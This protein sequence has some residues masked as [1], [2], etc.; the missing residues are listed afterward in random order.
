MSSLVF[1][2]LSGVSQT[3]VGRAQM[4]HIATLSPTNPISGHVTGLKQEFSSVQC[5][6]MFDYSVL[7]S[8]FLVCNVGDKH[9]EM[10]YLDLYAFVVT[11]FVRKHLSSVENMPH[12]NSWTHCFKHFHSSV[13][14]FS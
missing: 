11:T 7:G 5:C 14:T 12:V 3:A 9:A 4:D 6:L 1:E 8:T 13:L 10:I 2:V